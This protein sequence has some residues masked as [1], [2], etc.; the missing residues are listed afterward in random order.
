MTAAAQRIVEG[1]SIPSIPH[2]LQ[3]IL[4]LTSD[5]ASSGRALEEKILAEPGLVTHLLRTVNSVYYGLP[6]KVSSLRQAIVLL[7]Y[8]SVRSMATGLILINTF[9]QLKQITRKYLQAVWMHSLITAGITTIIAGQ[10]PREQK[11]SLMLAA[12]VHN[13]GH[14][15][16]AQHF[17]KNY[18]ALIHPNPFPSVEEEKNHFA[19]NHTEVGALLLET[20]KFE[21]KV[22]DLVSAHHNPQSYKGEPWLI[23]ALIL[24][25]SL[26][27]KGAGLKDYLEKDEADVDAEILAMLP[28]LGWGWK[29]LQEKKTAIVH[30]IE[31]A[32]RCL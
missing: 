9:N 18:D 31:L 26:A 16:L 10:R 15:V 12:M 2:A 3:A 1:A 13:I 14:L 5:P 29:E 17:E 22:I 28:E 25:E 30:S 21:Q 32:R 27:R 20:W 19:V 8:T 24:S 23:E 7:G 4:D 11:E 6:R